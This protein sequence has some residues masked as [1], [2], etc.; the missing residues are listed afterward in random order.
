MLM[1]FQMSM[2]MSHLHCVACLYSLSADT[3]QLSEYELPKCT[4]DFLAASYV[5]SCRL[6]MGTD[7]TRASTDYAS[8]CK[9][10]SHLGQKP[11]VYRASR[12]GTSFPSSCC[13]SLWNLK[14]AQNSAP[15]GRPRTAGEVVEPS[16][17]TALGCASDILGYTSQHS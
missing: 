3:Q 15:Q 7:P 8:L 12:P 14:S 5:S 11:M 13:S 2:L 10:S 17:T 9:C 6:V 1:P 16:R 4:M